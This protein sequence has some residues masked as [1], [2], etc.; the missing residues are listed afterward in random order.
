[1]PS[2]RDS[3]RRNR[4]APFDRPPYST[5]LAVQLPRTG[6]L[7]GFAFHGVRFRALDRHFVVRRAQVP[8]PPL[9]LPSAPRRYCG[10]RSR[11]RLQSPSRCTFQPV[12]H[13]GS[14]RATAQAT[15]RAKATAEAV[16]F[17]A[18]NLL[19]NLLQV[20]S[21]APRSPVPDASSAAAVCRALPRCR[22]IQVFLRS[23]MD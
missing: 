3:F 15:V 17:P 19:H 22:R 13:W 12:F 1:M 9:S 4:V 23:A 16:N 5:I 7:G 11:C 18:R 14:V 2:G 8:A 10:L 21:Q 20:P 6:S